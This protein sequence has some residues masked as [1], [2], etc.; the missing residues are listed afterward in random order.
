MK[1]PMAEVLA[2]AQGREPLERRA[3]ELI[4]NQGVI[5]AGAYVVVHGWQTLVE[6]ECV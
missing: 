1:V 4:G 6:L 3:P 5:D 2:G